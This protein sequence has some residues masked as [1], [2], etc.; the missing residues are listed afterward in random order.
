M[1]SNATRELLDR[2]QRHYIKPGEP[3]PGGVFL[4]EVGWNGGTGGRGTV[5]TGGTCDAIY[6]GFTTTSGRVL[7]GHELKVSRADWVKELNS[8]GKADGWADECHQWY[9]VVNDPNIVRPGEL[10]AGWGLMTPGRS[11]TRM[12]VKVPADTKTGHHPSWL[13]VRSIIARQ[14]TL[15]AQAIAAGKRRAEEAAQAS[16]R[17]QVDQAVARQRGITPDVELARSVIK[18]VR[19]RRLFMPGDTEKLADAICEVL[20]GHRL[21]DNLKG[22]ARHRLTQLET[23]MRDLKSNWQYKTLLEQLGEAATDA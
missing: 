3:L 4:P 15:R 22:I 14:D 7:V 16:I 8:P 11:K 10:P 21:L 20:E 23:A 6:I 12:D 18:A 17:E 19:E 2:L 5:G 9:L 13:A 1:P